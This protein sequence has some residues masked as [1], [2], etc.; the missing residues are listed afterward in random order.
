MNTF[1]QYAER[2]SVQSTDLRT[3]QSLQQY[4]NDLDC[5]LRDSNGIII[6]LD[7]RDYR[8]QIY[9]GPDHRGYPVSATRYH[10]R[11]GKLLNVRVSCI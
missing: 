10:F 9:N 11:N 3:E 1:D 2:L 6:A 8:H 7:P 5:L 4:S